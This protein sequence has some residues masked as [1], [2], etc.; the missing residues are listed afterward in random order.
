[1]RNPIVVRETEKFSLSPLF[2]AIS[3]LETGVEAFFKLFP[4]YQPLLHSSLVCLYMAH[5]P[6]LASNRFKSQ[7]NSVSP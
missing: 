5:E 7:V 3:N 6:S 1:M 4:K 2:Y